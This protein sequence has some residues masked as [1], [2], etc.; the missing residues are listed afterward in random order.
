ML[1]LTISANC[2]F[3]PAS[4]DCGTGKDK[5]VIGREFKKF[6]SDVTKSAFLDFLKILENFVIEALKMSFS[7]QK[8]D[9]TV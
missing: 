5:S 4:N 7:A 9:E 8:E 6:I 2:S 3:A 1:T